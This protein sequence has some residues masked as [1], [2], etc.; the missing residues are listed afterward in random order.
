ML[1]DRIYMASK[2]DTDSKSPVDESWIV[3]DDDTPE[4]IDCELD[5]S[6]LNPMSSRRE[7]YMNNLFKGMRR[8]KQKRSD[9]DLS[10]EQIS[11]KRSP[12][13]GSN[14]VNA[15]RKLKLRSNS[16]AD[17]GERLSTGG[18][19]RS[20]TTCTLVCVCVCVLLKM[21]SIIIPTL[22]YQPHPLSMACVTAWSHLQTLAATFLKEKG[23]QLW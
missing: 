17:E 20:A 13:W 5:D 1:P 15:F 22:N 10:D 6:V 12:G 8:L 14:V 4:I 19:E 21:L 11:E 23:S 9:H 7:R 3:V 2:P 18:G 16:F